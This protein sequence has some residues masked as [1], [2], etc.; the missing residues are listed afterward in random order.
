MRG[1]NFQRLDEPVVERPVYVEFQR[2]DRMGNLFDRVALAVGIVVHRVDA[3]LVARAVVFGV[4][5]AVHDRVAEEHVGM[6]HVDLGAQHLRAVG[7]LA[8]LHA[9]EQIEILLDR[10]VAPR[11][12]LARLRYGASREAYLF[13]RLV[14]DVRQTLLT[15][16]TA[17][18]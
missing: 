15:S 10:T 18:S 3:P 16:S 13:L 1:E 5:D 6:R 9:H 14:V 4:D 7:E 12:L 2:A 17:Q 11:R 8:V